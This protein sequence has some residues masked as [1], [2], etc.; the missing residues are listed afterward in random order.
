MCIDMAVTILWVVDMF[1]SK[2]DLLTGVQKK[3]KTS[4]EEFQL[5]KVQSQGI[6]AWA[7]AFWVIPD[8]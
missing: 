8:F 6:A 5:R 4:Y 1:L 3:K 2:M 7:M